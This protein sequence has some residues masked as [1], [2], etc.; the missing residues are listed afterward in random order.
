MRMNKRCRKMKFEEIIKDIKFG[1]I[2]ESK[3]REDIIIC[4][5]VSFYWYNIKTKKDGLQVALDSTFFNYDDWE[6]FKEEDDWNLKEGA[7][8]KHEGFVWY[9]PEDIK[10]LKAKILED[11]KKTKSRCPACTTVEAIVERRFGF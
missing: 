3:S 2:I 10:K 1:T 4:K 8:N 7:I 6:E 9:G 11:I 5:G